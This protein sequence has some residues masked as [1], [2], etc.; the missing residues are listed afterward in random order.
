MNNNKAD[1]GEKFMTATDTR[2]LIRE[3]EVI[4]GI[5]DKNVVGKAARG[6]IHIVCN[7]Y[8]PEVAKK[9]IGSVQKITNY[10]LLQ[11][12]F[13]IG[14]QDTVAD[15]ATAEEIK[16]I[17]ETA[18]KKVGDYVR[19]GQQ[20]KIKSQPG[21]TLMDS[22]EDLVNRTLND[23]RDRAGKLAADSLDKT[24]SFKATVTSGSKGSYTNIAQIMAYV[25]QQ[26]V[27]GKRIGYGFRH[28]S[29][30]HFT[31]FDY[32]SAS[33]GF[34][35]NSYLFGLTPQEFYFHAM[36]GREGLID[37]AVKTAETGYIQRK[38]VKSMEDIMVR[39]DGTVRNSQDQIIQFLY[40]EDGMDGRWIEEQKFP[41]RNIRKKAFFK[42]YQW[43]FQSETFG[44]MPH[45]PGTLFISRGVKRDLQNSAEAQELLAGEV[46][47]TLFPC[48]LRLL[49][50][51]FRSFW[52]LL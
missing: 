19:E 41:T 11:T 37:T 20:G 50:C 21:K 44:E 29:L 4:S 36:G 32:G 28:R 33:R 43:N 30:P 26:N 2:V 46:F 13:S 52:S 27:S 49:L 9:F 23:A 18:D 48:V 39:Y 34:V 16:S 5:I 38:L 3:G 45:H 17:V 25:G 8:D 24:N 12:G 10:W 15:K 47:A 6:T 35:K 42:K 14:V 7:E 22:F 40:G 1:P 31:K 51:A